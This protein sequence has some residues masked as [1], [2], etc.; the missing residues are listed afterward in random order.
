MS[1]DNE[2]TFNG[3]V[4][5]DQDGIVVEEVGEEGCVVHQLMWVGGPFQRSGV[6]QPTTNHAGHVQNNS[7]HPPLRQQP[8]RDSPLNVLVL[9][10]DLLAKATHLVIIVVNKLLSNDQD[11]LLKD[12]QVMLRVLMKEIMVDVSDIVWRLQIHN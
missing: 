7:E 3:N 12:R 4:C 9:L 11:N 6:W 10:N 1:A 8:V 2:T 5:A